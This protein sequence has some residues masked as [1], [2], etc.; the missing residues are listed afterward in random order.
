MAD[1]PKK[2]IKG[3]NVLKSK[4]SSKQIS[5]A[6]ELERK[7]VRRLMKNLFVLIK[8]FVNNWIFELPRSY[9]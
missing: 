6:K 1:R 9:P 4:G 2:F 8:F 3:H 5:K 7:K